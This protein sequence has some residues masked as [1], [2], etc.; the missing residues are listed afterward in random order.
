MFSEEFLKFLLHTTACQECCYFSLSILLIASSLFPL[1]GFKGTNKNIILNPKKIAAG[2]PG[3]SQKISCNWFYH[4]YAYQ[5]SFGAVQY[6]FLGKPL[7]IWQLPPSFVVLL[8]NFHGS[9][10]EEGELCWVNW[11]VADSALW[12][13]VYNH[14]SSTTT[15]SWIHYQVP[16]WCFHHH[17]PHFHATA[18]MDLACRLEGNP[19]PTSCLLPSNFV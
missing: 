16:E 8:P 5:I 19:S 15:C 7:L 13:Y 6:A 1:E 18:P 11:G 9:C 14:E 4:S 17:N 2:G 10:S 3:N 12:Q